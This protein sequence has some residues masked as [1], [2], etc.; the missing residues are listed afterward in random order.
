MDRFRNQSR[1]SRIIEYDSMSSDEESEYSLD[2]K[3]V[4]SDKSPP[5]NDA[6]STES[7]VSNHDD[8][9]KIRYVV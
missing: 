5:S 9:C 6:S 4:D 3:P 7:S 8:R 2:Q 1:R